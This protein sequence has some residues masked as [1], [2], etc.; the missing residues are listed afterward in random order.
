MAG[1]DH[2][3]DALPRNNLKGLLAQVHQDDAHLPA[4]V[5]IDRSRRIEYGNAVLDGQ[6]ATGA[7]LRLIALRKGDIQARGDQ[8]TLQRLQHH[9][10]FQVGFE[11]HAGT[12]RRSV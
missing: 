8:H 6:A 7:H 1:N 4:I 5:G 9:R 3:G 11:V 10:L 12:L 2:L